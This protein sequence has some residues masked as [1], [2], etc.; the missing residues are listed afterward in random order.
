MSGAIFSRLDCCGG[1]AFMAQALR[2]QK[3]NDRS[4][5]PLTEDEAS[6]RWMMLDCRS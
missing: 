5:A 3:P 1:E 6:N 4:E 2:L